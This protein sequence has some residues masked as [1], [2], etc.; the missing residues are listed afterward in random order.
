MATTIVESEKKP[1]DEPERYERP[2]HEL[3]GMWKPRVKMH[4]YPFTYAKYDDR[5]HGFYQGH[6]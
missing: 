4:I 1:T 6:L 2:L 3:W 5:T